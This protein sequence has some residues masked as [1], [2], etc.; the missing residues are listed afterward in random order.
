MLKLE[1]KIR[2]GKLLKVKNKY[3]GSLKANL[4]LKIRVKVTNFQTCLGHLKQTKFGCFKV[5]LTDLKEQGQ[6]HQVS[7]L[8]DTFE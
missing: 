4:N 1:F 2:I 6:G 5:N 3:F 8:S 7:N